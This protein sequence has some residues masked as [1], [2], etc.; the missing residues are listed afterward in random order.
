[1]DIEFVKMQIGGS[2][3]IYIDFTD[4]RAAFKPENAVRLC[5]RSFGIGADCVTIMRTSSRA[6]VKMTA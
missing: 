4:R 1:M 2:D 5:N 3:G 6:D